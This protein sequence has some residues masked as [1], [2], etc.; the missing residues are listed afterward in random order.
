M[1]LLLPA[2]VSHWFVLRGVLPSSA[3]VITLAFALA[4]PLVRTSP[5]HSARF[6]PFT[7]PSCMPWLILKL[8]SRRSKTIYGPFHRL[9]NLL[10]KWPRTSSLAWFF[11]FHQLSRGESLHLCDW[12][13]LS[14]FLA[15][16]NANFYICCRS[17]FGNSLDA[18]PF[19]NISGAILGS[20]P[21]VSSN[22]VFP[23]MECYVLR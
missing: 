23:V 16:R 17:H 14:V 18:S 9:R 12:L 10:A 11:K 5:V 4:H 6:P 22:G 21:N 1:L 3:V 7:H 2:T 8:L 15:R 19:N 20:R 13:R